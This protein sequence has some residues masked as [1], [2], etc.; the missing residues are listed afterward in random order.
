MRKI[1]IIEDNCAVARLYEHKLTAAGNEVHVT[2]NGDEGLKLIYELRPDLVL[3]DLMLPGKSGIEI[4]KTIRADFRYT[5]LP[6]MAYS[7][8]DAEV[9]EQAVE[10]GSTTIVSKNESS[11]KEILE[12]FNELMELSRNWQIYNPYNFQEDAAKSDQ[13]VDPADLDPTLLDLGKLNPM[14]VSVPASM[15]DV[16]SVPVKEI[17]RGPNRM[18]IVEDDL[19]T[20]CVISGISEREGFTPVALDDGED[21]YQLLQRDKDFAAAVIDIQLPNVLGTE[22]LKFMRRDE[23]LKHIP[24]IVMTGSSDYI[25][26]QIESYASGATCFLSKPF[27]RS[28]VESLFRTVLR[29]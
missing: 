11:F 5:S 18:L 1:V 23:R 28:M 2:G 24:A 8:A 10:A 22:L 20:S 3:L 16:Q 4:I 14:H 9:L 26:L 13:R 6:I 15:T 25:K 7:S 12:K 29:K 21:A 19:L 27:E 17:P